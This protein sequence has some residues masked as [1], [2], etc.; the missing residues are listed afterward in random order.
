MLL[1]ACVMASPGEKS[2]AQMMINNQFQVEVAPPGASGYDWKV[3]VHGFTTNVTAYTWSPKSA[4]DKVAVY[5]RLL[6]GCKGLSVVKEGE[7][8]NPFSEDAS[9]SGFTAYVACD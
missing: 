7:W 1:A 6:P 8:P 9:A 3:Y 2:I 4:T 5:K